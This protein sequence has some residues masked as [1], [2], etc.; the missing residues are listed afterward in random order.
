MNDQINSLER[1]G[2]EGGVGK[3]KDGGIEEDDA[4]VLFWIIGAILFIFIVGTH[5]D[6]VVL[7]CIMLLLVPSRGCSECSPLPQAWSALQ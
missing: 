6:S 2:K 7:S 5:D 3:R 1:G 4:Q